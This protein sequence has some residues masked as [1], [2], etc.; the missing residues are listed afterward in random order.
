MR[1]TRGFTLL[2]L[3]IVVAIAGILA[4]VAIPGLIRGRISALESA[5]LASLRTINSAQ[6]TY[7]SSCGRGGYAQTIA[8]L[9]KPVVTSGLQFISPDVPANGVIRNGYIMNLSADEGAVVVTPSPL[10]CNLA[11]MPAVSAYFAE[12]HPVATGISGRRAFATNTRASIFWNQT[13]A[14]IAPGMADANVLQ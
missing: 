5:S 14:I 10:T 13:G 1:G 12:A 4:A 3:M 8:D 11:T 6:S 9:Q 7:A 2:E